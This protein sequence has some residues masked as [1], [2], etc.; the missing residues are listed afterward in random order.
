MSAP[1][2][3]KSRGVDK[4]D[5]AL[6]D[7]CMANLNLLKE[8]RTEIGLS[9]FDAAVRADVSLTHWGM[10]E[11]GESKPG[12]DVARRVAAA[13]ESNIDDLWPREEL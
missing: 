8:R 11:R 13:L 9:Q 12:L 3:R 2:G 10:M 4:A 1:A 5:F 7:V 6:Q